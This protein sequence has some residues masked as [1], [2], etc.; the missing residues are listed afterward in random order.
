MAESL[1][2]SDAEEEAPEVS[3]FLEEVAAVVLVAFPVRIVEY[4]LLHFR[5]G[6]VEEEEA[7]RTSLQA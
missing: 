2:H 1:W 7:L 4:C 3:A 5:E 6:F